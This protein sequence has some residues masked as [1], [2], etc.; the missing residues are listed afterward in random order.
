MQKRENEAASQS[1]LVSGLRESFHASLS[2]TRSRQRRDRIVVNSVDLM[3]ERVKTED[4]SARSP[5]A[6]NDEAVKSQIEKLLSVKEA[7]WK[8]Q[9]NPRLHQMTPY[10]NTLTVLRTEP[11]P[12][13][14]KRPGVL[15][16]MVSNMTD[17]LFLGVA[18][19]SKKPHNRSRIVASTDLTGSTQLA[20]VQSRVDSVSQAKNSL[21]RSL[22]VG[23][24]VE[25][26]QKLKLKAFFD[27]V[28]KSSAL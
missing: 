18:A 17:R 26:A 10:H 14:K 4:A 8:Q 27:S 20:E 5:C 11:S 24:P 25:R 22:A 21:K 15:S 13:V 7:L 3:G 6:E 1:A 9:G 2:P 16:S 12:E 23:D 28:E 19:A